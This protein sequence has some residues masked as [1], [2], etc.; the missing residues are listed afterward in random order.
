MA[1]KKL[2][3]KCMIEKAKSASSKSTFLLLAKHVWIV[4]MLFDDLVLMRGTNQ[5]TCRIVLQSNVYILGLLL[6]VLEH[7]RWS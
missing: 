3:I 2:L 7:P 6:Q 5:G 4:K 1:P